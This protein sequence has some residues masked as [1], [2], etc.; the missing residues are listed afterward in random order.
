MFNSPQPLNPIFS[1]TLYFT[2]TFENPPQI[3]LAIQELQYSAG[4]IQFYCELIDITTQSFKLLIYTT[5]GKITQINYFFQAFD[6]QRVQIINNLNMIPPINLTYPIRNPNTQKAIISLVN[7]GCQGPINFEIFIEEISERN[8]AVGITKD[9]LQ[10]QN[11]NQVG[12]Q[13]L[14]GIEEAI[15]YEMMRFPTGPIAYHISNI[16]LIQ[17]NKFQFLTTYLGFKYDTSN[18]F[19]LVKES[20]NTYSDLSFD[21]TIYHVVPAVFPPCIN[22]ESFVIKQY[23]TIFTQLKLLSAQISQKVDPNAIDNPTIVI[24][25][26]FNNQIIQEPGLY[27]VII[28]KS[29]VY[30]NIKILINCKKLTKIQSLIQN[31][32]NG[33]SQQHKITNNCRQQFQQ[34]IF[35]LQFKQVTVAYQILSI[36][37]EELKLN[38]KQILYNHHEEIIDLFKINL[39]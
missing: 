31:Q 2:G 37:Y 22:L 32:K 38:L 7:F 8:I 23:T 5:L 39:E 35:N 28:G 1:Q 25:L 4:G 3:F 21:Y 29:N 36:E 16:D 10:F 19:H 13:I 24:Q 20:A 12:Y 27:I 18:S 15:P 26:E 14:I 30:I 6:D 17:G 33:F 34:L 11:L 9:P